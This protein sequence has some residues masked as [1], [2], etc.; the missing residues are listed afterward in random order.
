MDMKPFL[1][2]V[3]VFSLLTGVILLAINFF[4]T[5][6]NNEPE[7]YAKHYEEL[8]QKRVNAN[9]IIIGSSHAV[10]AIR[11]T[12]LNT[13]KD[14]FY[15]FALNG[16]SPKFYFKWFKHCF[17]NHYR[18][19]KYCIY[20][21]DWFLFNEHWLW[22][23]LEQDSEFF[24]REVF[25]QM[26]LNAADL[27]SSSLVVN[28]IPLLK[29]KEFD[30]L[31]RMIKG[32][33]GDERFLIDEYDNGFIPY[34]L[35]FDSIYLQHPSVTENGWI[36]AEQ[37]L[38]FEKLIRLIQ[39]EGIP[40]IFVFTPEYGISQAEY[41]SLESLAI[42]KKLAETHQIPVLNYNMEHKS[43]ISAKA[44]NFTDWGHMNSKG[45]R[46]FSALLSADLKRL[47]Y[48]KP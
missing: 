5:Q 4:L 9:T 45:S 40:L 15:N 1:L 35:P 22:R 36:S 28:R 43:V 23:Q 34:F 33:K 7:H 38:Y 8:V 44:K 42:I 37:R 13:E 3:F 12:Y 19:P 20:A 25:Y 32:E 41:G 24:S 27:N 48:Q 17:I 2:R 31:K 14:T 6:Y 26:W 11:P 29:Y 39:D 10:H 47:M 30:D 16:G 18:K 46:S 21:V